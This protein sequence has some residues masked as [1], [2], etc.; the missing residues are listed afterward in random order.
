MNCISYVFAW[1]PIKNSYTRG[2]A[3]SDCAKISNFKTVEFDADLG[4]LKQKVN[5]LVCCLGG[6][7]ASIKYK[8][9]ASIRNKILLYIKYKLSGCI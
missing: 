7:S 2:R 1:P 5:I 9:N 8:T 4:L 3:L 6:I